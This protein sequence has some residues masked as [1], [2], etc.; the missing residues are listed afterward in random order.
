MNCRCRAT[1]ASSTRRTARGWS[2]FST[3]ARYTATA[4]TTRPPPAMTATGTSR[5][6][7][8]PNTCARLTT[9]NETD[10]LRL[11]RAVAEPLA[12]PDTAAP[13]AAGN[14]ALEWVVQHFATLP[15]QEI[16]RS[17]SRAAA[18]TLLREPPP[19]GG[20]DYLE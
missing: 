12:H 13:L 19:E 16:G 8:L 11:R 7:A 14:R 3:A 4:A 6:T 10:F 9:I 2:S 1:P 18:E 15:D 5:R 17:L 20:R